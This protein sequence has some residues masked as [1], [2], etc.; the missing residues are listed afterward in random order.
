ML[1]V[2]GPCFEQQGSTLVV[3][4]F[5]CILQSPGDSKAQAEFQANLASVSGGRLQASRFWKLLIQKIPTYKQVLDPLGHTGI[6]SPAPIKTLRL[7]GF[8]TLS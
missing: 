4:K 6:Y 8:M 1:L 2:Q 7:S 5:L 3:P